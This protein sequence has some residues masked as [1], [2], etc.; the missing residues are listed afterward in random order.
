MT[1]EAVVPAQVHASGVTFDPTSGVQVKQL[2]T[3]RLKL[4]KCSLA[5]CQP[6]AEP[7]QLERT[8]RDCMGRPRAKMVQ[9]AEEGADVQQ[10]AQRQVAEQH[11]QVAAGQGVCAVVCCLQLHG[12]CLCKPA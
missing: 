12:R 3:I 8:Q 9:Q 11:C 6:F 1:C 10:L 7:K 4:G 2:C 5:G